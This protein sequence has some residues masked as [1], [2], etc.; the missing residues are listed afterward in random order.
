MATHYRTEDSIIHCEGIHSGDY[1]LCGI[2]PEGVDGD[3][4]AT[5]T[6]AP[7]NCKDCIAIKIGRASCRERV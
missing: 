4:R 2:A 3:E 1:M 7:I 5:A 6:A